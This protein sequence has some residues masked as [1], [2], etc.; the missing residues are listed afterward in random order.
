MIM[1][2]KNNDDD[3]NDD[4]DDDDD[5]NY[6]E[7][8]TSIYSEPVHVATFSKSNTCTHIFKKS[9]YSI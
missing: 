8:N 6:T 3:D 2:T 5:D 9:H 4:D 7:N 1:S